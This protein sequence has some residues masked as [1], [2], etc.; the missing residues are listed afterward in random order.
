MR[1]LFV[2]YLHPDSGLVGAVR[3]QRFAEELTRRGHQVVLLCACHQGEPDT[4]ASISDRLAKHTWDRPLVVGVHDGAHARMSTPTARTWRPLQRA[5]T[6]YRLVIR[7]GP[8]WE[9]QRAARQCREAICRD[10]D[11]ELA[12]ASFGNLDALAIARAYAHHAGIPWVM[13][14]KDPASFYLPKPLRSLLIHRLR[15][16]DAVTLNSEFQRHNNGRWADEH[17]TLIY[18]GVEPPPASNA[19]HDPAHVALIGSIRAD[20]T[21][22]TLLQGFDAWRKQTRPEATLHYFGMDTEQVRAVAERTGTTDGL[23][24]EGQVPRADLL[25]RCSRMTALL[26]TSRK[27]AA[28]HHKLLELAALGRPLISSPGP[29]GESPALCADYAIPLTGADAPQDVT[30]ALQAST[31]RGTEPMTRLLD[32]LSWPRGAE[33]LEGIFRQ[34]LAVRAPEST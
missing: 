16:A 11:P 5:R 23:V 20:A 31:T 33:R 9:W 27:T 25:E 22:A 19:S 29:V 17:S 4:P 7:G 3:L 13:D 34:A 12:Y 32:E 28:F 21:L 2:N 24:I 14:L 30:A 18:S 1:L 26:F 15:D 6:A 8:F 10:F